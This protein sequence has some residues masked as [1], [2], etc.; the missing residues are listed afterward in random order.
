MNRLTIQTKITALI[1]FIVGFSLLLAG[2]IV[3]SN[4]IDSQEEE[5]KKRALLTAQTIAED[6]EIKSNITGNEE[7]KNK[8]SNRVE[9]LRII[10]HAEYIVVMD[11]N[12][13]R[14]SHPVSSLVGK[15][16]GGH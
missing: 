2:I 14:L 3:I 6:A 13:I 5:L 1:F 15:E 9:K 11:M 10:H 8:I 4:F 7:E 16:S 12:H